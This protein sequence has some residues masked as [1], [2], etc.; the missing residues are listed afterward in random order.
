[1]CCVGM[2]QWISDVS[3]PRLRC[4]NSS[5]SI[6]HVL[7][8]SFLPSLLQVITKLS[9][10][11]VSWLTQKESPVPAVTV[12]FYAREILKEFAYMQMD[13]HWFEI[14]QR[15]I[16]CL[17][18]PYLFLAS[19]LQAR[20]VHVRFECPGMLRPLHSHVHNEILHK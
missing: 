3:F 14:S 9:S 4:I 16:W 7:C 17:K 1:M 8:S 10:V 13:S 20:H 5:A 15:Y 12:R 11:L 19:T 2:L 6:P 18:Q